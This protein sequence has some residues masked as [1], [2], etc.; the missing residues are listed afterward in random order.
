MKELHEAIDLMNDLLGEIERRFT[1][2]QLTVRA[3]VPM[4]VDDE[5][6]VK[7]VYGKESGQWS[8]F[9]ESNGQLKPLLESSL[10]HRIKSVYAMPS[11]EQALELAAGDRLRDTKL[12][13]EF[14][15]EFLAGKR[16]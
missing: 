4:T 14:A 5:E 1:A 15:E 10:K 12:A 6:D 3:S 2:M 7:L 13:I 16:R 11:L 9:I 8:L